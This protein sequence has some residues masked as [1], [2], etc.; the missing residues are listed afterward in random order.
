MAAFLLHHRFERFHQLDGKEA[1]PPCK[2]EQAKGEEAIDAFTVAGDEVHPLRIAGHLISGL[3]SER[4]A[5]GLDQLGKH[6]LVPV[7]FPG[8]QHQRIAHLGTLEIGRIRREPQPR[9]AFGMHGDVPDRQRRHPL[10][11]VGGE[12][13]P[14]DHG[15]PVW[16]EGLPKH[17]AD[18]AQMGWR[19]EMQLSD[20]RTAPI[21]GGSIRVPQCLGARISVQQRGRHKANRRHRGS[22]KIV[23]VAH[24]AGTVRIWGR[25]V[26]CTCGA[27]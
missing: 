4:N 17:S 27:S 15:R 9:A 26:Q 23:V 14:G 1:G 18:F 2:L 11:H 8:V 25:N 5:V 24:I 3:G 7:L 16:I 10:Q 13:G 22:E 19:A 20:V 12:F 6:F 21:A